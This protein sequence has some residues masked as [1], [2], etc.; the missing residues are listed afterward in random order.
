[1]RAAVGLAAVLLSGCAGT[2][3]GPV[4]HG[5]GVLDAITVA[6][7]GLLAAD[8]LQSRWMAAHETPDAHGR[9]WTEGNPLLGRRPSRLAVTAYCG[10][11]AAG[12]LGLRL[13]PRVPAWVRWAGT[14]AVL[15]VEAWTVHDNAAV[16]HE[17]MAW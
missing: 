15:A 4:R 1:M 3:G 11:W 14:A 16:Q 9:F 17:G 8:T 13:A 12:V 5:A 2:W 7:V 10:A 6:D